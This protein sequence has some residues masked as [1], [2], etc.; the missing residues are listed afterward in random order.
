MMT[1]RDIFDMFRR[2]GGARCVEIGRHIQSYIDDGLDPAARAK[3]ASHLHACRRCGLTAS[4]YRHLKTALAQAASPLPPEPLQRL[5][6]LAAD[7]T[8]GEVRRPR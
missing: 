2:R 6:S 7:L 8:A 5:Q 4:E 3:V 1:P